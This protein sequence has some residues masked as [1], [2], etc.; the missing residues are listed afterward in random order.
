MPAPL[1]IIIPTLN[2]ASRIGPTIGSLG[3][4]LSEGIIAE[5][6]ISDG[7]STDAISQIADQIGANFITGTAGRGQQLARGAAS[8]KAGWFLFLHADTVLP[9]GWVKVVRAHLQNHPEKA[10]YFDLSFDESALPAR[11]TA[12]WANLRSRAFGLPYGDQGLLVP[13]ALYN[14]AGGYPE[15]AR[16]EDIAI[17]RALRSRLRPLGMPVITSAEKYRENGW[18][19][20]GSRNLSAATRYLIFR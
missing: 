12:G 5:L 8:A 3:E 7:G 15:I 18:F 6:I 1:S 10:A 14:A 13:R 19:R 2:A 11:L 4:G 16:M 9:D 20:Q 17:A